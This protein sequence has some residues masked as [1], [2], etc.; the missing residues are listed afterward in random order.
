MMAYFEEATGI[1]DGMDG[2]V[3]IEASCCSPGDE[4]IQIWALAVCWVGAGYEGG[5]FPVSARGEI[6]EELSDLCKAILLIFG[7][8]IDSAI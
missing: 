3:D 5:E 8:V 2:G 1:D 4:G 6:G 7:E